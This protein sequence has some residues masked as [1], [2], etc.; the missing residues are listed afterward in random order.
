MGSFT[1][2]LFLSITIYRLFFHRIRHFPGPLLAALS[3]LGHSYQCR[4]SQNHIVLERLHQRYGDFVRTGP[5]E[6]TIFHPEV[7]QKL[8][9]P[10]S[11]CTKSDWYDFLRPHM[12]ITTIRDNQFHD[13]RRRLW[14]KAFATP[15]LIRYE[16][17]IV[18]HARQLDVVLAAA[19]AKKTVVNFSD[20][21]YWFSFDV[22][23]LFAL[24]RSFDML[25]REEWHNSVFMLRR[26]TA[27]IGPFSPVPWLGRVGFTFLK[28]YWVVKD[29]HTMI[30][31]CHSRM[32]ER[33]QV[34]Y[35]TP[36]RSKF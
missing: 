30:A 23:G 16:E 24:S 9:A 8:N 10:G 6:I 20:Y 29:W 25:H 32:K 19:A 15:Q 11:K 35:R 22:M 1:L 26:A 33:I 7:L 31:W 21:V 14:S 34:Q 28:G 3:K 17:G 18:A 5:S 27:L 4:Y 13:Q 36:S 2:G 12:G